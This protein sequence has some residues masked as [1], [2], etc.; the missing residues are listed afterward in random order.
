MVKTLKQLVRVLWAIQ[1]D[2]HVIVSNTEV[3]AAQH[4]DK[5]IFLRRCVRAS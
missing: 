4:F 2:L 1:K 5:K 3:L